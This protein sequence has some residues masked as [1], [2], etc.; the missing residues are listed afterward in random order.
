MQLLDSFQKKTTIKTKTSPPK[1]QIQ[2]FGHTMIRVRKPY[3]WFQ[4]GIHI[5][6][7]S[8]KLTTLFLPSIL[9]QALYMNIQ[10]LNSPSYE[11]L[12]LN[13]LYSKEMELEKLMW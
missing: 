7:R 11:V 3:S 1:A 10:S 13:L 8:V 9:W 6:P 12:T 4:T 5:Q 2:T